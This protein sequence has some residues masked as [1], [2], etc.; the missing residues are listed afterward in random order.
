M[1]SRY[2]ARHV[3]PYPQTL[4]TP[5]VMCFTYYLSK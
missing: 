1:G 4:A 3:T 5:L 2:R